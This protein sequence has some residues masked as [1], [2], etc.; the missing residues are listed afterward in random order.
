[1]VEV[2][3]FFQHRAEFL[4]ELQVILLRFLLCLSQ[5]GENLSDK[6]LLNLAD[7]GVLLKDLAGD[8]QGKVAGVHHAFHETE[9]FGEEMLALVRD[10][11]PLHIEVH[12]L[13]VLRH[14]QVQGA[15]FRNIEEGLE[16]AGSFGRVMDGAER[17]AVIMGYMTIELVVLLF[18]YLALWPRPDGLHGVEGLFL[19]LFD[20]FRPFDGLAV[21]STG[22]L[23]AGYVHSDG[24][25]DVVGVF[26]DY[27]AKPPLV[28]ILFHLILEMEND[29]GAPCLLLAFLDGIRAVPHRL[30][31]GSR[32]P[33]ACPA[34]HQGHFV[35]GH[36]R[37]V[38]ADAKLADELRMVLYTLL[39]QT[40]E[41]CLGARL[42]DGADIGLHLFHGHA[43][44]VVTD[45]EGS[46]VLVGNQLYLPIRVVLQDRLVGVG[47]EAGLVHGVGGVGDE[48]PEEDLLVGVERMDYQIQ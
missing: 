45:G 15:M 18:G 44:A 48:F 33:V 4:V 43:D 21:H 9:V 2:D 17:L 11:Y 8:V 5:G 7:L 13:A 28:K 42:G 25:L 20:L 10:E 32:C 22:I 29:I 36:E 14:E 40:L 41:K 24:I 16:L 23:L 38:E 1:M 35:G 26:L 37:G 39:L 27:G 34:R 47:L 19:G 6:V 3:S 12:A 30:P 46:G 31:A